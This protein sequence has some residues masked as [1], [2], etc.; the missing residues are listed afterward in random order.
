MFP[1]PL[2]VGDALPLLEAIGPMHMRPAPHAA[3]LEIACHPPCR[4]LEHVTDL[5]GSEVRELLPRELRT[6]SMIGSVG[7]VPLE[8]P[9]DFAGEAEAKNKL[10]VLAP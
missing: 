4:L 3:A 7:R 2:Q 8:K 5:T 6:V 9:C 1:R 10:E